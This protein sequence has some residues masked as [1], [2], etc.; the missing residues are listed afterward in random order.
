M[1]GV[2]KEMAALARD[3]YVVLE[4]LLSPSELEAVRAA[5]APH[6]QRE[7]RGRNNFEGYLTQRGS[8]LVARHPL[9]E[10]LAEHPRILRLC[11]ALL[12]PNYLLTASQAIQIEPGETPQPFH[13]D[14]AFYAIARPRAPVSVSTI[15]AI[16]PFTVENGATQLVPQSHQWDDARVSDLLAR[17]DFRT[18]P[19]T[20]RT[21][22]PAPPLDEPLR[23]QV[24][25]LL[26]PPGAAVVFLGTLVH[27]GGANRS[28]TPRLALSNQ[29]CQ[30]WAR[31][32][33]SF[34]LAIPPARARL[35]SARLQSLLGY[36]IHPPFMG[37][38]GGLHPQRLLT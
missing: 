2:D 9:F 33:E 4:D 28:T 18:A 1:D 38:V 20:A 34:T 27:R 15:W 5:L 3:G 22:V 19:P 21:P 13:T 35:M 32:Q 23:G 12:Q 14:D 10:V 37:H 26:M 11:D 24:I 25:D 29:Y 36:S 30:P 6:L 8:T 17:V 7:Q 31:P 16:D